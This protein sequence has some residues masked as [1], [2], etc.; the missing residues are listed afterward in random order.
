M[1]VLLISQKSKAQNSLVWSKQLEHPEEEPRAQSCWQLH[2]SLAQ[3]CVCVYVSQ[4][5]RVSMSV[6]VC[7]CVCVSVSVS[8]CVNTEICVTIQPIN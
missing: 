6:C 4:R 3:Q 7:V 1:C 2:T 5:A 8:V